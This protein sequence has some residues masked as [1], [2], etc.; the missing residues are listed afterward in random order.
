MTRPPGGG[1]K[2]RDGGSN[3][4]QKRETEGVDVLTELG[5][6]GLKH[7]AGIIGE[8]FL[9]KL[10]DWQSE[11]Q[12]YIEMRHN[13]P[14]V[15][16][17]LML[18][19]TW[20]RRTTYTPEP[21]DVN[22]GQ[23]R[24]IADEFKTVMDDMESS[25]QEFL[26]ES[27][28]AIWA[29]FAAFEEV[30][31]VRQGPEG[32]VPSKFSDGKMGLR[33]MAFRAQETLDH[34][35]IDPTGSIM[36]MWQ[37]DPNGSGGLVFLPIEKLFHFRRSTFKNNPNGWSALRPV[38]PPYYFKKR[39]QAYEGIGF[40]RNTAGLLV[41]TVPPEYLSKN[42]TTDQKAMVQILFEYATNTRRDTQEG[43]V[44]P[45]KA[46]QQG[47]T[48]FDVWALNVGDRNGGLRGAIVDYQREMM[49]ALM[50][51]M[52][53]L[54]GERLGTQALAESKRD[55]LNMSLEALADMF[56]AA[57]S[58]QTMRRWTR[59]NGYPVEKAPILAHGRITTPTFT[60]LAAMM[61]LV[62]GG[63]LQPDTKLREW[64]RQNTGLPAAE[65]AQDDAL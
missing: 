12:T 36:G 54:G 25:F 50:T 2:K 7:N 4:Q 57:F 22:D 47:V 19:E 18:M 56:C 44:I 27:Y 53:M 28:S 16:Y 13:E 46:T 49:L 21:S 38:Y 31:K 3:T 32:D 42:A 65:G 5:V 8:E 55:T 41:F 40:E 11:I 33:K 61:P 26:S 34:W 17:S 62:M 37:S 43:I 15:A 29:G 52:G 10:K 60:E 59:Y 30:W 58:A 64:V 24:M 51:E 23:A 48:G 1:Q 39:F 45:A 63:V 14:A 20:L 35:E 6:T 9:P